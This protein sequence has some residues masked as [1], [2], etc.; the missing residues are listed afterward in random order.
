MDK[1]DIEIL[2]ALKKDTNFHSI[3]E[4][5][6][7]GENFRDRK[8]TL[9]KLKILQRDGFVEF[10]MLSYTPSYKITSKGI[11]LI[12]KGDPGLQII[13]LLY[14]AEKCTIEELDHFLKF[15]SNS[16]HNEIED[17]RQNRKVARSKDES[18]EKQF[19]VLTNDKGRDYAREIC[20]GISPTIIKTHHYWNDPK[21]WVGVGITIVSMIIG[22]ASLG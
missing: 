13:R 10:S 16:I 4:I 20:E 21:F 19:W 14:Y 18:D 2:L 15:G 3:D 11:N 7:L 5:E 1:Y 6:Q 17:L 8:K 22:I 12:W 9:E